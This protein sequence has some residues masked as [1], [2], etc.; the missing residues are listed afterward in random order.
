MAEMGGSASNFLNAEPCAGELVILD[1]AAE[2]FPVL[3]E[4]LLKTAEQFI[5]LAFRKNEVVVREVG[6]LLFQLSFDL[7]PV[8]F[9]FEFS[10]ARFS[11]EMGK[12]D[13][14][15]ELP[16]KKSGRRSTADQPSQ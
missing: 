10:H 15:E 1:L 3:A 8:P 6:V 13:A 4:P 9:D 5:L 12:A 7:I 14:N 2:I 16:S 11:R